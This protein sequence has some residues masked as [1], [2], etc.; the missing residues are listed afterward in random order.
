MSALEPPSKKAKTGWNIVPSAKASRT[1]NPI[2]AIVDS[3]AKQKLET[4]KDMIPLSLGDP[5]VFGNL[6]APDVLVE[7]IVSNAR[8]FKHNGYCHSAGIP[9]ARE[10]VAQYFGR[11]DAPLTSD[12]VILASGGSGALD[13]AITAALNEGDNLLVP[14]PGFPLYQV[15]A[16]S[17]GASVKQYPLVPERDWEVDCASLEAL[18]DDK[19]RAILVN[20]PSNPCGSLFSDN[21]LREILAIAEKYKL[22]I[23]SD[24]IYGTMTF[25]GHEFTPIAALTTT[26]PVLAVGGMAKMFCVPG[27]RVGWIMVID[28]NNVLTEGGMRQGLM[29]LSQLI[30]GANALVQSAIPAVL[31]KST[32]TDNKLNGNGNGAA[33]AAAVSNGDG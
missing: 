3:I 15:I 29:N 32:S 13:I 8:S 9:S 23:I 14:A 4:D 18:I 1:R 21:N 33:A 31:I 20:N 7:S 27:W 25:T 6:K 24:E 22:L 30:L 10:A 16:E 11:P 17:N 19:T 28:R 2:R 5:T 26:V 12:D